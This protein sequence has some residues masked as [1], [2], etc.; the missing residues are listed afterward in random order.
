MHDTR[1]HVI[2]LSSSRAGGASY[3]WY[4]PTPFQEKTKSNQGYTLFVIFIWI[5][6]IPSAYPFLQTKNNKRYTSHP[7]GAKEPLLSR[8]R[9][10][11]KF[12]IYTNLLTY[13]YYIFIFIVYTL[14]KWTSP[15]RIG[16]AN[17]L[18]KVACFIR[19]KWTTA[20][21]LMTWLNVSILN[22]EYKND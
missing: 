4:I 11:Y 6:F 18:L 14:S 12:D 19:T 17:G 7:I 8:K 3:T 1:K 10:K 20:K 21:T 9:N 15:S 22:T 16:P 2:Y 13:N 5:W